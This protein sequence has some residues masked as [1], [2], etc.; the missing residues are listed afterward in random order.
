MK[1]KL[2]IVILLF[3]CITTQAQF[4]VENIITNEAANANT[5]F[6]ADMDG[7]GDIDVLS[8]SQGDDTLAWYENLDGE[9]TFS[10]EHII[11]NNLDS[12]RYINGADMDGDGD[13][14]VLST[15]IVDNLVV[16]FENLDGLGNFSPQNIIT[17]NLVSPKMVLA[18]DIDSDGDMDVL[19]AS[20]LDNKITWFENL[21]GLGTFGPQHIITSNAS[22]VDSVYYADLDGDGIKDVLGNRNSNGQPFWLKHLDGLGTFGPEQQITDQT[23]SSNYIIAHDLDGDDYTDI[24]ITEFTGD[25]IGW[26]KNTD[27]LGTFGLRQIITTEVDAP[28][29]IYATDLDNDGDIDI[30]SASQADDKV[31]WYEN[32]DGLG[33]FGPQ[34]IISL[35]ADGPMSVYAADLDGDGY[36]DAM[37]ASIID[38]KIAWYKNLTYLDTENHTLEQLYVYPNPVQNILYIENPTNLILSHIQIF[39]LLGRVVLSEKSNTNQLNISHLK[40][41]VFYIIIETELGVLTRKMIKK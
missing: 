5:V 38:Y 17:S 1:L 10:D 28:R 11:T 26:Y 35:Y 16:W 3:F 39:D 32:T 13:I 30:L 41:G 19:I 33:N 22:S 36:K 8:A 24:I 25:I 2:F 4:G 23:N 29:V 37:S 20:R 12:T 21:D 9:G 7:D 14:D 31:A 34:Q 6:A 15:T 40:G 18:E 27:G